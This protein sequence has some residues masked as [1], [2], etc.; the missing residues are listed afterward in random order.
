MKNKFFLNF[1][2]AI[3][4][5]TVWAA[6]LLSAAEPAAKS[7]FEGVPKF[8]KLPECTHGKTVDLLPLDTAGKTISIELLGG[9]TAIPAK[10]SARKKQL[11]GF[12]IEQEKSPKE[13]VSEWKIKY[14]ERGR[15][16][17]C[18]TL[19][20]DGKKLTF[21]WRTKVPERILAPI[22]NCVLKLTADADTHYLALREPMALESLIL[23]PKTAKAAIKSEKVD[24]PFPS[25]DVMFIEIQG[26]G[27]YVNGKDWVTFSPPMKVSEITAQNPL[28]VTFSFKDSAGN[29][30]PIFY[31][32]ILPAFKTTFTAQLIPPRDFPN[33]TQFY[34]IVQDPQIDLRKAANSK[35]ITAI[36]KRL[37]KEKGWKR[38]AA[39]TTKIS[40]LQ[41]E[42]ATIDRLRTTP[43]ADVKMR[44][45]ADY[46]EMQMDI[47][48]TQVF[49]EEQK[50]AMKQS[51]KKGKSANAD[52]ADSDADSDTGSDADTDSISASDEPKKKRKKSK[53][54]KESQEKKDEGLGNLFG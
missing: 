25:E 13:G 22:G 41:Q 14:N 51:R 5:L 21:K 33:F 34:Q 26:F 27:K 47:I 7:I 46:G 53:K 1:S 32:D 6:G 12:T 28:K 40:M 31:F 42:N 50:E 9:E 23:N 52:S 37:D 2:L 49:T 54:A 38:S 10:A 39:D 36:K 20:H 4:V 43:N 18:V 11:V 17:T 19:I 44:V 15:K 8:A 16:A 35:E 29:E 24:V 45:Y 48:Q 30:K 3:L